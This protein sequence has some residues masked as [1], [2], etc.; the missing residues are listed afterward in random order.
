MVNKLFNILSYL[1]FAAYLWGG[2][3][4]FPE[5]IKRTENIIANIG[6]GL[7][8]FGIGLAFEGFRVSEGFNKSEVKLFSQQKKAKMFILVLSFVFFLPI[9]IGVF[10]FHI[11]FFIPNASDQMAAQFR[12]LGYGSLSLGIGGFSITKDQYNRF[13]SFSKTNKNSGTRKNL[14]Q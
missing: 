14:F 2:Y 13:N 5:L 12:E 6:F 11:N 7:F 8:L 1:R 3:I 10:F 4:A 9:L